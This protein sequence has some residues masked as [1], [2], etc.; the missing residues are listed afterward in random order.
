[1]LDPLVKTIEV[2]CG[3][4]KAFA[5]FIEGMGGWWP[6]EKF[7]VSAMAKSTV[8]ELRVE[9]RKGGTIVEVS[10]DGTENDWGLIRVYEPPSFLSMDFHFVPPGEPRGAVTLVEVRF[11]ALADD[12]T[13]V[14][15]TQSNWE[16][17]GERAEGIRGGYDFGWGMI[18]EQA[19]KAACG[20]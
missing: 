15:L 16:A 6:V 3:Q 7:S 2:P 1:M 17:L 5:V 13:R 12:R 20:G 14:E 4:A 11:T 19:Y 10:A 9:A 18:F 8:K